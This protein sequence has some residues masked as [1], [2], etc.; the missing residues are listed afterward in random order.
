IERVLMNLLAN[1]VRHTPSGGAVAVVVEPDT[2]HVIVAVEDT[3]NGLTPPA[4][5]RMFD[6]FW[7]EDAS[8]TRSTGGAGLGLAI[9]QGLVR[10]HGGTIW[11]ENRRSGG[12]RVAFTLPVVASPRW[13]HSSR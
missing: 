10:A 6:L 3:G 9:A 12:A 7:R 1:A 4:A 8:R 5:Q 11:A 2:D 13:T